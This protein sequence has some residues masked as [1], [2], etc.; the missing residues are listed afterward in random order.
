MNWFRS[1]FAWR[2]GLAT[3]ALLL[4]LSA[5]DAARAQSAMGHGR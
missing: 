5:A 2:A 1:T 3:G 4:V